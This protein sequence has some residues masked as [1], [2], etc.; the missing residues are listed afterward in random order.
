MA[1][2]I[3]LCSLFAI[4]LLSLGL[5]GCANTTRHDYSADTDTLLEAN[6]LS[7][8]SQFLFHDESSS[9]SSIELSSLMSDPALTE[10][11][12]R[13]LQG[14]P[15]V[16]KTALSIEASLWNIKS[17]QGQRLPEAS[18]SLSTNKTEDNNTRFS[19][20]LNISW[21]VDLWRRLADNQSAAQTSFSSDM[22]TLKA[23]QASLVANVMKN[24]L[25]LIANQRAIN[26][27]QQRLTLLETNES[28]IIKRFRNGLGTLE[29]LDEAQTATSKSRADLAEYRETL[30]SNQRALKLLLGD[31]ENIRLPDAGHYPS[32]L[33]A[34]KALPEQ[35]LGQRPDLRAAYLD[36]QAADLKAQVAYKDM[37]PSFSLSAALNDSSNHLRD[38]LFV[39]PVWSLLGQLTAPLFQG[40]KLEAA[41]EIAK[42]SVAQAYQDYRATLLNAVNEVEDRIGQESVLTEQTQHIQSALDSAENNL[43]LYQRKYRAG[44]V[45]LSDLIRAQQSVYNLQAQLDTLQYQK[46]SNRVDLGLALGLGVNT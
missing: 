3:R 23:S 36:I 28:I 1:P 24:W 42:L 31:N 26:I 20:G 2:F 4:C 14:N 6:Q 7:S 17:L 33:L 18:S 10:L 41:H 27:E 40:H 34:L 22:E 11:I 5:V 46:L 32:V 19:A 16:T 44:L 45:E 13:A 38:A 37:L 25:L 15:N 12:D 29:G 30:A 9:R 8:E 43:T 35:N 21:E 39:S